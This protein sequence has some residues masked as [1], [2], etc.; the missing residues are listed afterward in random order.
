MRSD[1]W[2]VEHVRAGV[3]ERLRAR[4]AELVETIFA[5]VQAG[6]LASAGD[7]DAEYLAGLRAAVEAAV[8]YSLEGIERGEEWADPVPAA[9]VQQ[10]RRAAR[11]GVS[12]D[13]VLRR[14]VVGNAFLGELVLEEADRG[15]LPGERSVLR[16]ALRA[17]ASVLDR[18]LAAVTEEYRDELARAGRSPEQHRAERVKWLLDG[19]SDERSELDYEFGGWHL[20]LI[21]LGSGAADAVR[22][23]AAGVDRRLLSVAQGGQSVWAWLGGRARPAFADVQQLVVGAGAGAG[24]DVVLAL[25]EPGRGIEGWRVTHR[26]AQAALLVALRRREPSRVTRYADIALLAFALR[27]EVLAG[28]LAEVYLAPLDQQRDGGVVSRETLR[29]YLAAGHNSSSAA[30]ALGVARNTVENRLRAIEQSLGRPLH[31]CLAELEVA[32]RLEELEGLAAGE[33]AHRSA[34]SPKG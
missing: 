11:T 13:T 18:L 15:E 33:I 30:A 4:R 26:Q 16:G 6:A 14:Y 34:D 25:G 22:E 27:D 24:D 8:E 21:A 17:Q 5:R 20:G 32:F 7:G 10:A 19:G 23:L 1:R 3:V 29:A 9:A 12:L 2:S 28:S 31:T